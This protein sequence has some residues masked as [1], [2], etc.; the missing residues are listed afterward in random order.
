MKTKSEKL[1]HR[2]GLLVAVVAIMGAVAWNASA[3]EQR[4]AARA[5][6]N[7]LFVNNTSA[8]APLTAETPV[9]V[10]EAYARVKAST[11]NL[12]RSMIFGVILV[13]G[14]LVAYGAG[15][16]ASVVTRRRTDDDGYNLMEKDGGDLI[17]I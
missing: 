15:C 1:S 10:N 2:L 13:F 7:A 12:E 5:E 11:R 6:F 17:A 3:F 14:G 8:S 9:V 4:Q 16:C